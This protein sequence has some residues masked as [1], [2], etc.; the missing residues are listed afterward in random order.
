MAAHNY[1]KM[2]QLSQD[3]FMDHAI[4]AAPGIPLPSG[5]SYSVSLGSPFLVKGRTVGNRWVIQP[6]EGWDGTRSGAP[7]ER[8]LRR[9]T[10]FGASGAKMIWGGE[11]AAVLP[12]GRANPH[13]LCI[14]EDTVEALADLLTALKE[15]H[16]LAF[17]RIDD[18]LVGLQLTHSGR[19]SVPDSWGEPR[20]KPVLRHPIL[21]PRVGIQSS[22]PLLS[23][24]DL[25]EIAEAFVRAGILASQAGFDFVDIKHCHGYLGHELLAC[26]D[27]EG[28]FGGDLT[29]RVG[30][31][32]RIV[33]ALRGQCPALLLGV[34]VSAFDSIPFVR[35]PDGTGQPATWEKG[36]PYRLGFGVNQEDP[37]CQ[38]LSEA[39]DLVGLL[40]DMGIDLLN[41]SGGSP[42]YTP[43]L[44]RPALYPPSDGYGPPE[45]PLVGVERHIQATK[46]LRERGRQ[47]KVVGSGY[48]YLQEFLPCVAEEVVGRGWAD[49]VGIGRMALAYP[50]LPADWLAKKPL[51]KRRICRTFSDCTTAP[52]H[53]LPSGCYPLDEA[54]H[55]CAEADTLREV[56]SRAL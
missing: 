31:L 56:K 10:R 42:Y 11:A 40:E 3:Q 9:W 35:G 51:A 26:R 32:R 27:R 33:K 55:R 13:Q 34:R 24:Q 43:H 14:G 48:T 20:P 37:S 23:D 41:V 46:A 52:R 19:F 1:P 8:T 17:G 4:R 44:I 28:E 53:R 47:L 15:A 49:A 22:D 18:L 25:S 30:L 29:H 2:S 6:M 50:D 16:R 39:L 36:R 54:Y 45:D 7:T 12:E 5:S 38:D 21:D